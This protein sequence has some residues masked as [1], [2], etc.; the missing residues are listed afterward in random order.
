MRWLGILGVM[1]THACFFSDPTLEGTRF[2]CEKNS[3][4]PGSQA[5]IANLC[6]GPTNSTVGVACGAAGMCTINQRCCTSLAG[7]SECLSTLDGC[8]GFSATCDGPED[9]EGGMACCT[10]GGSAQCG[11]PS[12][13]VRACTSG[14]DCAG[15]TPDC[16]FLVAAPW[17]TCAV[18]PTAVN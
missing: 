4:C 18:C 15:S 5:C 13:T 14:D 6:S 7:V 1:I 16:C 12:C 8:V 3:D 10:D 2:Q 9:C 17:G 11:D